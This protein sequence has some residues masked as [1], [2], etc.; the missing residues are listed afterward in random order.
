VQNA[1]GLPAGATVNANLECRCVTVTGGAVTEN[2]GV[3]AGSRNAG[4]TTGNC[5]A[6]FC[7]APQVMHHFVEIT[8][9]QTHNMLV[10]WPGIPNPLT[11]TM[12]K[13]A[14]VPVNE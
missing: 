13:D 12:T 10:D 2:Y 9:T 11:M 3:N 4:T 5:A 8:V 7:A 14:K 1:P 6:S